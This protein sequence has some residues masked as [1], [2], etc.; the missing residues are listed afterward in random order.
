MRLKLGALVAGLL[1]ASSVAVIAF[2]GPGDTTGDPSAVTDETGDD[3][4]VVALSHDG[5]AHGTEPIAQTIADA[6]GF[7]Q[8]DVLDLHDQ[9]IGFG[10]LFQLYALVAAMNDGT[11]VED[12][13]LLI[14]GGT[15]LGELRAA[16]TP[17]QM[18]ALEGGAKNLGSLISSSHMPEGAGPAAAEAAS[19]SLG[20]A[21]EKFLTHESSGHGP[22]ASVPAGGP[23]AQ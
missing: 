13:L 19:E 21:R 8:Q 22:P 3:A 7:N 14:D 10:A 6:F 2:A 9:E 17:E 4:G 23:H 20:S 18:E 11:T 1:I 12:L 5:E 15:G 16:L